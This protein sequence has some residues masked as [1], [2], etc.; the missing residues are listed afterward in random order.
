MLVE[1]RVGIWCAVRLS[2]HYTNIWL[3]YTQDNT[4]A[5]ATNSLSLMTAFPFHQLI[6]T[7][8]KN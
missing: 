7:V 3:D 8:M 1:S 5:T 6:E 2:M 4:Y